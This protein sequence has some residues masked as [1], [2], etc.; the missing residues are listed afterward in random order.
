[1]DWWVNHVWW[2][3]NGVLTRAIVFS[4]QACIGIDFACNRAWD[5]HLRASNCA[6][7]IHIYTHKRKG[8][9][10]AT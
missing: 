1:M 4:C 10:A 5:E 6:L 2:L 9:Q 8:E 7:L 3:G